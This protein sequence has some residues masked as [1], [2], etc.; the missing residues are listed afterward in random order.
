MNRSRIVFFAASAV[1]VLFLV[2]GGKLGAVRGSDQEDSLYKYLS[3]FTEVLKLVQDA[4][5]DEVELGTLMEG[6][7]DSATEAMDPFSL[8]VPAGRDLEDFVA[9]RERAFRLGGLTLLK[10][11]GSAFVAAL[12]PG[13]PAA[14]ADLEIGDVVAELQGESTRPMPV[15]RLLDLLAGEPGQRIEMQIIRGPFAERLEVGFEL[16]P[17][18]PPPPALETVDGAHLLRVG[19]LREESLDGVRTALEGAT[20]LGVDRMVVDLRG[21]VGRDPETAYRMAALW[22]EGDLGTLSRRGETVQTFRN[23]LPPVWKGK[24]VVLVDR[25]T[26]GPA[27][28]FAR[29]LEQGAGAELVGETTFGHAGRMGTAELSSGGHLLFT[30]AFYA[31][32]DGEILD[33]GIEPALRVTNGTRTFAERDM[34]LDELIQK[35]GI[36]RLLETE[37]EAEER[38]AA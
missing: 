29:V 3:V 24:L 21:V 33:Q 2:V 31:G 9:D 12:E 37:G 5:V 10:Y 26:L 13:S 36:Q 8:Y 35:R 23:D 28:I 32:P 20:R 17:Y 34:P 4:Y 11:R 1:L 18:T 22:V 15:W 16:T 27:E 38:E 25:G 14:E 19:G 30:D 6:A 7:L